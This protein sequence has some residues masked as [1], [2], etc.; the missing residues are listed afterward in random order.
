M[1]G[2][3]TVFPLTM[4]PHIAELLNILNTSTYEPSLVQPISQIHQ[5][6]NF[7]QKADNS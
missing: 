1:N 7:K 2:Q 5:A 4:Q 3:K 6:Q